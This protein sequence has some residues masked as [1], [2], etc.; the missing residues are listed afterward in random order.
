[1]GKSMIFQTKEGEPR[2]VRFKSDEIEE[3]IPDA[4]M[5]F[6]LVILKDGN[7]HFVQGTVQEIR[8]KLG[9]TD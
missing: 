1:M 5:H 9:M 7:K 3:I 2:T 4:N 6:S 8:E